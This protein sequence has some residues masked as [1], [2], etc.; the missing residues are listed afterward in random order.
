MDIITLS[1]GP[2][3]GAGEVGRR[4]SSELGSKLVSREDITEKIGQYGISGNRLDRAR[5]KHLGIL[6]RMDLGWMHYVVFVRAAVS[7]EIR[8]GNLIYVGEDGRALL[9]EFPNVLNV[10]VVGGLES[11]VNNLMKRTDYVI[12]RKRA[13]RLIEKIDEKESKWQRALVD[14]G[15]HESSEFDLVVDPGQIG[16]PGACGLIRAA[17][18]QSQFQITPRAIET[19]ELLT[20]AAELRARIAMKD[21]VVDVNVE[22]EVREGVIVISGSVHSA[23]D[24]DAIRELLY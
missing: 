14:D 9:R 4:L 21:N 6:Q 18:A 12:S 5:R 15:W 3:S 8:E 24:L 7:K 10:S 1:R 17:A 13:K 16:V 19:M 11:R 2:F 22:V 23:E 20:V